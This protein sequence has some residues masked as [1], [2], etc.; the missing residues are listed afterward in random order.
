MNDYNTAFGPSAWQPFRG[1]LPGLSGSLV[2]MDSATGFKTA[3]EIVSNTDRFLLTQAVQEVW[4]SDKLTEVTIGGK[5][6]IARRPQPGS[7]F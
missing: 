2:L 6:Y 7:E 4:P 5:R 3:R 1:N